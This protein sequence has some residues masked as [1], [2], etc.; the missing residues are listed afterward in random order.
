M[1][2]YLPFFAPLCSQKSLDLGPFLGGGFPTGG[3]SEIGTRGP[4]VNFVTGET[5]NM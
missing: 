5:V 2:V 4:A 1:Y 3:E